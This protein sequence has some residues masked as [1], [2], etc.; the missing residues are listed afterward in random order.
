MN[1]YFLIPLILLVTI[2][3]FSQTDSFDV[4]TYQSP[5]FFSK[6]ELLSKV[7]FTMTN[8]DGSFCTIT[9]YKSRPAKK[10]VMSDIITQWNEQVVKR[11]VKANKKPARIMT[12]QLWDGWVSSLAVGNFHHKK[13]KAVVMLNSFRKDKMTACVVFAMSDK[14]FKGVVE[15]FSENL[16]LIK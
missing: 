12:E 8:K 7:L 10:D 15:N 5:K 14:S 16:H 11:L 13:K 9:L 6:S 3:A 1:K 4:F 2:N